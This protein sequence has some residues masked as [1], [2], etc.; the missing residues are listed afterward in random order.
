MKVTK[1]KRAKLL[2]SLGALVLVGLLLWFV[3]S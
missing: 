1:E 3:F 2:F